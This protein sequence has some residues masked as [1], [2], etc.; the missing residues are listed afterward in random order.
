MQ[1]RVRSLSCCFR[2]FLTLS[3]AEWNAR[4]EKRANGY[5]ASGALRSRADD[6]DA[7]AKRRARIMELLEARRKARTTTATTTRAPA[8][9]QKPAIDTRVVESPSDQVRYLGG[10]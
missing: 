7:Y 4:K 10:W 5:V 8:T 9:T 6:A 2:C 1:C 3:L